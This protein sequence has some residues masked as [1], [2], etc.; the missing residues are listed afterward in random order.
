[1]NVIGLVGLAGSGK[2]TVAKYIKEKYGYEFLTLSDIIK[3]EAQ[4]RGLVSGEAVEEI[5]V[6]LSKFGDQWRAETE[7]KDIVAEKLIEKIKE[8]KLKNVVADGARSPAEIELLR[9]SFDKFKLIYV[10]TDF[11]T[12]FKRRLKDDP[13][14]KKEKMQERDNMDIEKKGLQDVIDMA[15]LIL[16]NNGTI[17]DLRHQI[18]VLMGTI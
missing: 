4:K 7:K 14:A 2:T 8:K 3:E 1:M 5:K 13:S 11:E 6:I 10:S 18:D 16:D 15:D 17:K 9:K 12:R